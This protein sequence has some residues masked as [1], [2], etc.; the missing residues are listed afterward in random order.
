MPET[1]WLVGSYTKKNI[2]IDDAEIKKK[3][4][5]RMSAEKVSHPQEQEPQHDSG[6]RRWHH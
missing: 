6:C 3:D 1:N 4:S 2:W 5:N